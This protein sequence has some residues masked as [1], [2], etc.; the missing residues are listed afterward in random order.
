MPSGGS[1]GWERELRDSSRRLVGRPQAEV[2]EDLHKAMQRRLAP[3]RQLPVSAAVKYR[4]DGESLPKEDPM[5]WWTRQQLQK[6]DP[7]RRSTAADRQGTSR[8]AKTP[9]EA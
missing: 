2:E 9:P 3:T 8:R 5:E 6:A 7:R 1:A 4:P